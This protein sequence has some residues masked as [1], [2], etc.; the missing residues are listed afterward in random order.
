MVFRHV[1]RLAVKPLG[2]I[3]IR[4][5]DE[6]Q[7][8]IGFG[9]KRA[10]LRKERFVRRVGRLVIARGILRAQ[11]K[12]EEFFIRVFHLWRLNLAAARALIA[13]RFGKGA[14]DGDACAGF[15]RQEV[16]VIL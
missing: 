8:N 6:Q 10:G 15:D 4:Q 7:R 14:D 2:L 3:A 13:R 16:I 1:Q 9:G 11:A 5:A 12:L